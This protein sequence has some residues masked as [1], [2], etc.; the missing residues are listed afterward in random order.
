MDSAV[1]Y[2]AVLSSGI[3]SQGQLGSHVFDQQSI[4]SGKL[5]KTTEGTTKKQF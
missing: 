2:P 3:I 1:Y 4:L 5:E